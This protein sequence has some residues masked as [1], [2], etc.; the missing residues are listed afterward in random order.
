MQDHLLLKY[1]VSAANE[2]S[3]AATRERATCV[4]TAHALNAV[5]QELGRRSYL[6][7]VETT[8]RHP[9]DHTFAGC[10]LGRGPW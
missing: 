5:L 4:L 2:E 6:L 1:L 7:R 8:V 9:T 10:A 3:F